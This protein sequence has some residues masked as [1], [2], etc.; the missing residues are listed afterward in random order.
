MNLKLTQ[1]FKLR[2]V[3]LQMLPGVLLQCLVGL[4]ENVRSEAIHNDFRWI[5]VTVFLLNA[6][7]QISNGRFIYQMD[8]RTIL[9]KNER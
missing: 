7:V 8:R 2:I 5:L 1:E 4:E 9:L 6:L 3:D